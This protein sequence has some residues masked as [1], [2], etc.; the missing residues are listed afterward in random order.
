MLYEV[1]TL[2][3]ARQ[4]R[5]LLINE[6]GQLLIPALGRWLLEEAPLC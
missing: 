6:Q 4:R 2:L 1:I 3:L 5:R